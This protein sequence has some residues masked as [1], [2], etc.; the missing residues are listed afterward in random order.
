MPTRQS[1]TASRGCGA[2]YVHQSGSGSRTLRDRSVAPS[3]EVRGGKLW[4]SRQVRFDRHRLGSDGRRCDYLARD[5]MEVLDAVTEPHGHWP[6][7]QAHCTRGSF[8]VLRVERRAQ[9]TAVRPLCKV[10]SRPAVGPR[11][12][13]GHGRS[14]YVASHRLHVGQ[15]DLRRR[16]QRGRDARGGRWISERD[17]DDGD[18]RDGGST[19]VW[20]SAIDCKVYVGVGTASFCTNIV[21]AGTN[22]TSG[23]DR[24]WPAP[25]RIPRRSAALARRRP[26]RRH[27]P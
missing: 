21:S 23:T 4:V 24:G 19:G 17:L 11:R 7:G 18:V 15:H 16:V 12:P 14:S 25:I 6:G 20:L 8:D 5:G 27:Q 2:T 9:R 13:P 22:V 3:I 1:P 26:V 10:I